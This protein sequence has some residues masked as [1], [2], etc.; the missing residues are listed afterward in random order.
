MTTNQKSDVTSLSGEAATAMGSVAAD[1]QAAATR[2]YD[3]TVA[4][5][6][7]QANDAKD[8]VADEVGDVATAL[9]RAS[10]ELRGG[11]VQERILGQIA[12]TLADGS[13]ALR[14]KDLGEL[15]HSAN[16][17]AREN[18]ALFLGGAALL[19]FAISR[20]AKASS[21]HGTSTG[22]F[23]AGFPEG[24]AYGFVKNKPRAASS[25]RGLQS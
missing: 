16:R 11:S 12:G 2:T 8:T 20:F 10:E 23:Y 19:G 6:K 9:R 7:S 24:N 1:I 4:E 25:E 14:D 18:P 3:A 17:I 21:D 22:T 15:I 5:V 13:D